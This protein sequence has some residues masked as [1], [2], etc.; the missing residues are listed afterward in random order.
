MKRSG[1]WACFICERAFASCEAME[2][3]AEK[4]A[5][6]KAAE[7]AQRD[8]WARDREADKRIDEARGK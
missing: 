2:V 5:Q 8:E 3:H 7:Y 4:C 6:T 1:R